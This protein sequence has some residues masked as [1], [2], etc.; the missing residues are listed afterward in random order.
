MVGCFLKKIF[1]HVKWAILEN[2]LSLI[3]IINYIH[4]DRVIMY[5]INLFYK[6]PINRVL[7][8]RW[9]QK[10]YEICYYQ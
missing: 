5:D 3:I 6:N 7:L 4:V 1:I 9:Q 10:D 2:V 8:V